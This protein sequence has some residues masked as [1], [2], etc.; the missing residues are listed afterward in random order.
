M[1]PLQV[2]MEAPQLVTIPA[3]IMALT[4]AQLCVSPSRMIMFLVDSTPVLSLTEPLGEICR[5]QLAKQNRCSEAIYVEVMYSTHS[6][7]TVTL[8]A[9]IGLAIPALCQNSTEKPAQAAADESSVTEGAVKIAEVAQEQTYLGLGTTKV[10]GFLGKHLRLPANSA[11]LVES[12][13]PEGPAAKAGFSVDD[14]ITKVDG[15]P[16]ASQHEL[17]NII[18]AKQPGNLLELEY[19][20]EGTPGKHSVKLGAH[21]PDPQAEAAAGG[22]LP[23]IPGEANVNGNIPPEAFKFMQ[24]ALEQAGKKIGRPMNFQVVP[25]G[26]GGIQILPGAGGLQP[27]GNIDSSVHMMDDEGSIEMSKSDDGSE[28]RVLDKAGKEVWSGAWDTAQDKAAAPADIRQRIERLN[29]APQ[30]F[31]LRMLQG[32]QGRAE[33]EL[34]LEV[35]PKEPKPEA[36]PVVPPSDNKSAP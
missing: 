14:I 3:S 2:E 24:K 1:V 28:V 4:V 16:V 26:A 35:Q 8:A 7:L 29:I 23:M 5:Y 30:G 9:T 32:V 36:P 22:G 20:R 13:D 10:P 11:L 21:R 34:K 33:A 19:I 15:N 31:G 25:G 18:H 6:I 27:G 12:V 17:A